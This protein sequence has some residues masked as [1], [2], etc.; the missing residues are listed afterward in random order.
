[1]PCQDYWLPGCQ[2]D[3]AFFKVVGATLAISSSPDTLSSTG[4]TVSDRTGVP[5]RTSIHFPRRLR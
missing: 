2:E 4:V 3:M 1:M 5:Y